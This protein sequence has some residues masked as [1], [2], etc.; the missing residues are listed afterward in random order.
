MTT[1]TTTT[2]AEPVIIQRVTSPAP[3]VINRIQ[4]PTPETRPETENIVPPEVLPEPPMIIARPQSPVEEPTVVYTITEEFEVPSAATT[5]PQTEAQ[6]SIS[7]PVDQSPR[8]RALAEALFGGETTSPAVSPPRINRSAEELHDEVGRKVLAATTALKSPSLTVEGGLPLRRKSTK[9]I[10]LQKIS[11]PH[12]VSA[13][14]SVDAIPLASPSMTSLGVVASPQDGAKRG[15]GIGSRLRRL[16]GSLRTKTN[17]VGHERENSGGNVVQEPTSSGLSQVVDYDPQGLQPPQIKSVPPHSGGSVKGAVGFPGPITPP[18]T[19]G[20]A[21]LKGFMSRL[22]RPGGGSIRRGETSP[23]RPAVSMQPSAL[24]SSTHLNENEPALPINQTQ[25]PVVH[26]LARALPSDSLP[27]PS[28]STQTPDET[29]LKQ[30][31]DAANNLGLDPAALNELLSNRAAL[32]QASKAAPWMAP[33]DS[34]S[35][36]STQRYDDSSSSPRTTAQTSAAV[37][38]QASTRVK[39]EAAPRLRPAR[40]GGN[41]QSAVVRRTIIYPATAGTSASPLPG[42]GRSTGV[43]RKASAASSSNKRRPISFQ[44]Q[45]SGKSVHDRTPTP[46]PPRGAAAKRMSQDGLPPMPGSMFSSSA[47]PGTS[48]G[49]MYAVYLTTK[50]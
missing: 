39:I 8:A 15:S 18:A 23:G 20:P 40:E 26:A 36:T 13:S 16:G 41:P 6:I 48:A 11:G 46:P 33:T 5:P 43:Q 32:Q 49:I 38:R 12:L 45:Y 2:Q 22:R 9:R 10:D 3:V 19:A 29:S 24:L 17:T 34:R 7:P 31:F 25:P 42:Q 21:G 44:S 35:G 30:L 37:S 47:R 1:T 27:I 14:M 50:R 4:S 28:V